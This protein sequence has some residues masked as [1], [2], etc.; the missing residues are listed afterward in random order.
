MRAFDE[1]KAEADRTPWWRLIR[2]YQL[3]WEA[4]QAYRAERM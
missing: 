1:V 2:H 3:L 4:W